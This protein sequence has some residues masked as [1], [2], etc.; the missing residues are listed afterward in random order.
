M[1]SGVQL[2]IPSTGI[3]DSGEAIY[4]LLVDLDIVCKKLELLDHETLIFCTAADS[5]ITSSVASLFFKPVERVFENYKQF[6]TRQKADT[7]VNAVA[8]ASVSAPEPDNVV[9]FTDVPESNGEQYASVEGDEYGGDTDEDYE[10]LAD[11]P[12][13]V[14]DSEKIQYEKEVKMEVEKSTSDTPA[15]D[16]EET[17][18]NNKEP[19]PLESEMVTD[20]S[21]QKTSVDSQKIG[22]FE[23]R[24]KRY[25]KETRADSGIQ[26]PLKLD[27]TDY[28]TE[29]KNMLPN[30]VNKRS[31]GTQSK[32]KTFMEFNNERLLLITPEESGIDFSQTD[33]NEVRC[34][35]CRK[36]A[37]GLSRL[38][39]HLT[40][41]HKIKIGHQC[42]CGRYFQETPAYEKH[43]THKAYSMYHHKCDLCESVFPSNNALKSHKIQEHDEQKEDFMMNQAEKL[44]DFPCKKCETTFHHEQH[45]LDHNEF[46]KD[47]EAALR[48]DEL[49]GKSVMEKEVECNTE[50]GVKLVAIGKILSSSK[51]APHGCPCCKAS[52]SRKSNLQRHLLRHC[53][54]GTHLCL[55]CGNKFKGKDGLQRHLNQHMVKPYHCRN[56][57]SRF[58]T[59]TELS[60]HIS[61]RC[62]EGNREDFKCDLCDHTSSNMSAL[63]THKNMHAGLKPFQCTLCKNSFATKSSLERHEIV[64]HNDATPFA[65]DKCGKMFK[66]K[67]NMKKHSKVH[68]EP[69]YSCEICGKACT[70]K[71]NLNK[72]MRIHTNEKPY[73][74]ELCGKAYGRKSLLDNHRRLHTG[75]KPYE[76]TKE[77]CEK[78][79]RSYSNLKQHMRNHATTHPYVCDICGKTFKQPGRM[80]HHRKG[81]SFPFRWPCAYCEEKFKSIF[82][83]KSHLAKVHPDMRKDIEEKA[84]IKLYECEQCHKV[85][86]DK[87]DLTRHYY[88]HDNIKPFECRYCGK[89]FNDKSNMRQHEKIHTG[90]KHHFCEVCKKGFIHKRDLRNHMNTNHFKDEDGAYQTHRERRI[91]RKK[92][93]ILKSLEEQEF[94]DD[95]KPPIQD[96]IDMSLIPQSYKGENSKPVETVIEEQPRDLTMQ[97]SLHHY[98]SSHGETPM[99]N[100]PVA[101]VN[102]ATGQI[103]PLMIIESY[104]NSGVLG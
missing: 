63:Q 45:L 56:C 7:K 68:E 71:G 81:H 11:Q 1:E 20:E 14:E 57:R 37:G 61:S 40:K 60:L 31:T 70:E 26:N 42:V 92:Q 10:E 5:V 28:F 15:T 103:E 25:L 104:Q 34:F 4:D 99:Y 96:G 65:C 102:A 74:C 90:E 27:G 87:D 83:Y 82:M 72:H 93:M 91:T 13:T 6:C 16:V 88:I 24:K 39:E 21:V 19:D 17:V 43:V 51:E 62:K 41:V 58:G 84:N 55:I 79:F 23:P 3:K 77:G 46:L 76:C 75:E 101:A 67:D 66:T 98:I 32:G 12:E 78:A 49:N 52:F 2:E 59:D 22:S 94:S 53:P 33:L 29:K 47:C 100:F 64:K 48:E 8:A 86:G 35:K 95:S 89:K 69:K 38:R 85:Y 36:V 50:T 97:T 18:E 9:I 44:G 80:N 30:V 73:I 54:T